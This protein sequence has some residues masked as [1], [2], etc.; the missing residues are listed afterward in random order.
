MGA[1]TVYII[2]SFFSS[3]F[4]SVIFTVNLV[5]HVAT[6][7]LDPLQL[8]LVGTILEGTVFLFEI[9]T[10][11]VADLK[12]RR[13][14]VIIGYLLI[15]LGFVIEGSFPFFAAVAL[16][17]GIWGFGYTF[18][19]G[20]IQAWIVDEIGQ[21]RAE[22]AFLRGAQFRQFGAFLGI[23]LSVTLASIAIP[24]PVILGGVMMIFL[25]IFLIFAM[26]ESGFKPTDAQERSTWRSMLNTVK[27]ARKMTI[28]QP[29]LLIILV[30]G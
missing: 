26:P 29:T 28:R 12:S 14:S 19:S 8:V 18:T 15:G 13:L 7:G 2:I 17:Q 4:F 3:F 16:G 24:L 30:I 11:I 22:Q 23:P 20:A 9:P 6:V 5:Y 21:A 10:G 27:A 1:L 25:S